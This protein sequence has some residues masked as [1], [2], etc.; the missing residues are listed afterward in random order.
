MADPSGYTDYDKSP[1]GSRYPGELV[2]VARKTSDKVT[3]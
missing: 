1:Y 2:C 3:G